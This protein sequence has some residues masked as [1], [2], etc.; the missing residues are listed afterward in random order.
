M[1]ELIVRGSEYADFLI[2]A[3]NGYIN[4]S[5]ELKQNDL[6]LSC[7]SEQLFING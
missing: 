6:M 7:F 5:K 2:V 3:K 1:A 4:G